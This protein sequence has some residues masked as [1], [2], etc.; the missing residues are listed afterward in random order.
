[1]SN[2]NDSVVPN[3]SRRG[4]LIKFFI[5]FILFC[6]LSFLGYYLYNK[7]DVYANNFTKGRVISSTCIRNWDNNYDCSLDF[8]YII[9]NNEYTQKIN[10]NSSDYY[11]PGDLIDLRYSK[12]DKKKITVDTSSNKFKIGIILFFGFILLIISLK[13]LYS[14]FT[15]KIVESTTTTTTS[16]NPGFDPGY[17]IT[18]NTG[19]RYNIGLN[20]YNIRYNPGS[21]LNIGFNSGYNSGF[22]TGFN[23]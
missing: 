14:V 8:S 23:R 5:T 3:G 6:L 21:G 11:I 20:G 15:G 4:V 12:Y 9:D 17:Y 7:E 2:G 13:F 18:S 16:I 22:N 1:L 19:S 10:T